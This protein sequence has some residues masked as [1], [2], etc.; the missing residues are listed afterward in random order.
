MRSVLAFASGLLALLLAFIAIPLQ[1]NAAH[2]AD[3]QGFAQFTR[4]AVE[5]REVQQEVAQLVGARVSAQLGTS[6]AIRSRV[7]TLV[8][9]A[10]ERTSS[11]EGFGEAWA[12][13][14][15]RTHALLFDSTEPP[16]VVE[17]DLAPLAAFAIEQLT[18]DLPVSVSPPQTLVITIS[19]QD[20]EPAVEA[21]RTAAR[22]API[23]ILASVA[24]ALAAVVF[25]R[26]RATAL[27]WLGV[28]ALVVAGLWFVLNHAVVPEYLARVLVV[29]SEVRNLVDVMVDRV[30]SSIDQT[31]RLV[32]LGGGIVAL[33]GLVGRLALRGR[34]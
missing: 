9:Q 8:S 5:D 24:A 15:Q 20:P 31:L 29:D 11:T 17:A 30:V 14:L 21:S 3:E 28:G 6:E 10:L 22:W 12:E 26:R 33:A 7:A 4:S 23:V 1:W 27:W 16:G 18:T 32:A 13:S 34:A 2:V 19:N 25:A